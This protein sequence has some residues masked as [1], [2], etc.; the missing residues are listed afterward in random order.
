MLRMSAKAASPGLPDINHGGLAD[1]DH[2]V[3]FRFA[4]APAIIFESELNRAFRLS[5]EARP[6][7]RVSTMHNRPIQSKASC[8]KS[9]RARNGEL[10]GL[11]R[12]Q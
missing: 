1:R 5:S 9:N 4:I 3:L 12:F 10:Y 8:L 2:Y 6:L 11:S 7:F